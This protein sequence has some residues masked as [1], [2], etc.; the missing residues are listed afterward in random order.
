MFLAV[1]GPS[2]SGKSTFLGLLAGLDRPTTGSI[3]VDGVELASLDEDAVAGLRL[4]KIGYVFQNGALF[5]SMDVFE[6]VRLG[7][8]DDFDADLTPEFVSH[9]AR[10]LQG[11]LLFFDQQMADYCAQLSHLGDLF[12]LDPTIHENVLHTGR[13][14][15]ACAPERLRRIRG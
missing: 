4:A 1:V 10:Q 14:E 13:R 3:R 11:Y 9:L 5:D 6:N 2:G 12:S 8:I 15:H 7:I